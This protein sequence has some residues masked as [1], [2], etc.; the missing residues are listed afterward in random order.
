MT[1][2]IA[3]SSGKPCNFRLVWGEG[4]VTCAFPARK[5]RPILC[6]NGRVDFACWVEGGRDVN[7]LAQPRFSDIFASA[8]LG[9]NE[10]GKA[11]ISAKTIWDMGKGGIADG[12]FEN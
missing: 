4:R 9:P 7:R 6:Q 11:G 8:T 5:I 1:A 3:Q 12:G 10:P 2:G